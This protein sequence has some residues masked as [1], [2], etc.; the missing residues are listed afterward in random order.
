MRETI[1]TRGYA[2]LLVSTGASWFT[3]FD[4]LVKEEMGWYKVTVFHLDEYI[5][6]PEINHAS[7]IKYLK[8]RFLSAPLTWALSILS[9]GR[10]MSPLIYGR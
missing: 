7:F 6:M 8:E 2:R 3:L 1:V 4:A 9:M 5:N 10:V